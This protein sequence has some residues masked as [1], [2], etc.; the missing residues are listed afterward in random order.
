MFRWWPAAQRRGINDDGS[1]LCQD[2]A[3]VHAT[4]LLEDD[5]TEALVPVPGCD[6][7]GCTGVTFLRD[8]SYCWDDGADF[9]GSGGF[10]CTVSA[11]DCDPDDASACSGGADGDCVFMGLTFGPSIPAGCTVVVSNDR[12]LNPIGTKFR[13]AVI[14]EWDAATFNV[15]HFDI[16]ANKRGVD[17]LLNTSPIP[18]MSNDGTLQHYRIP[19]RNREI[20]GAKLF[21]IR[22]TLTDGTTNET[23]LGG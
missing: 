19:V 6:E 17:R 10:G 20:K 8:V 22:T 7:T 5:G 3:I 21:R 4:Q 1:G 12:A 18:P 14:F 15:D 13:G 23:P 2:L 9:I 11:A 16:V